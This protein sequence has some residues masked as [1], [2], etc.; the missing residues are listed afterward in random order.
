MKL[1]T[2]L[3][4]ALILTNQAAYAASAKVIKLKDGSQIIGEVISANNGEY[5]VRT[6]NL[7][8]VSIN[9]ENILSIQAAGL[10]T[11]ADAS[12]AFGSANLK[13]QVQSVQSQIVNDGAIM[14]D[15]KALSENKEIQAILQNPELMSTIMSFDEKR[16]QN[17]PSVKKLLERKDVQDIMK[18]IESKITPAGK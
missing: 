13:E 3:V 18:Q 4:C 8:E 15:I 17:D 2:L 10:S 16:I 12:S 11:N 5:T 1:K 9:D 14:D 7:G 6:E